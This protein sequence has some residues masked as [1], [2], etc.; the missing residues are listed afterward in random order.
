M[1]KTNNYKSKLKISGFALPK[2]V[3]R[4]SQSVQYY[5]RL[6]LVLLKI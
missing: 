3:I 6:I 4:V 5:V 2:L 1:N